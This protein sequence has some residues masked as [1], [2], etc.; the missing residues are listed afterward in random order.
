M[1]GR[2]SALPDVLPELRRYLLEYPNAELAG[3]TASSTG[4]RC[5]S[6]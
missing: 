4:R 5:R 6:D 3:A 2:A 1:I